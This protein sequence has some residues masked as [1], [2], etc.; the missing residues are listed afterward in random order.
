MATV[1]AALSRDK[2]N[3][4]EVS[5]DALIAQ[6]HTLMRVAARIADNRTVAGVHFPT[7]SFA[8]ATLGMAIGA[9]VVQAVDSEGAKLPV[10]LRSFGA[11]E[12]DHVP[13]FSLATL[14][15]LPTIGQAQ[16]DASG[17][18]QIF[19]LLWAEARSE[20]R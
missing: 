17:H 16:V 13:D 5:P 10:T 12:G 7:D 14:G 19:K 18:A 20:W 15:A 9:L 2:N 8:G 3:A 1:L 11:G 6:R 4:D